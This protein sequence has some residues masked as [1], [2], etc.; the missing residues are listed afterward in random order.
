MDPARL[1]S[2]REFQRPRTNKQLQKWLG[3]CTSRGEFA[4]SPLKDRLELQQELLRKNYFNNLQWNQKQ[5]AEF[6]MVRDVSSNSSQMLQSFNP[7]LA[8]G[9]HVDTDKTTGIG[10]ILFQFDP[11]Y[12]PGCRL[13][14]SVETLV[15]PM[16]FSLQGA[17]SVGAKGSYWPISLQ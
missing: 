13:P 14:E 10:Y 3:L 6:E 9:L 8:M 5:V 1:N 7:A 4:S 2:I 15:S 16:N 12:P 17:W 11:R